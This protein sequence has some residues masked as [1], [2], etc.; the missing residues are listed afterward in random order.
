M[1]VLVLFVCLF[2]FGDLRS[3]GEVRERIQDYLLN[4]FKEFLYYSQ[5]LEEQIL[6]MRIQQREQEKQGRPWKEW[7]D[8]DPEDIKKLEEYMKQRNKYAVKCD[9]VTLDYPA[10]DKEKYKWLLSSV[11]L[12]LSEKSRLKDKANKNEYKKYKKAKQTA[13]SAD[14][15]YENK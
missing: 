9:I 13:E 7:S 12:F 15:T 2:N 11:P 5:L 3:L 14:K 1:R 4:N 10:T 8:I 6:K